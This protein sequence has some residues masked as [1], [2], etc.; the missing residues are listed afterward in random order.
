MNC[1]YVEQL[2]PLYVG[3][4][5]EAERSMSVADHLQSC[6]RCAQAAGEYAQ[7]KQLL[8]RF[9]A[10][11]FSDAIYAGIRRQVLNEIER[12]SHAPAWSTAISQFFASLAAPRMRWITAALVLA[13]SVTALYFMTKRSN[14]IPHRVNIADDSTQKATDR[15]ADAPAATTHD[16]DANAG[17]IK[18]RSQQ[19]GKAIV[20]V[21]HREMLLSRMAETKSLSPPNNIPGQPNVEPSQPSS[22]HAPLRVEIQTSDRNIRIIWLSNERHQSG[23]RETSKG[24]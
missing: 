5:L 10:P 13:L 22:A 17:P 16:K 15:G 2:L 6:K 11:S 18:R 4:D 24:I 21:A 20:R 1:A 12:E 7:A 9:E 8:Q 23:L 19:R 14:P 3:R